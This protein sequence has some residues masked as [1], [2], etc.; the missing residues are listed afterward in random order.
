MGPIPGS[1]DGSSGA[2]AVGS[3]RSRTALAGTGLEYALDSA[4]A[5]METEADLEV[6]AGA[7]GLGSKQGE[8]R[9]G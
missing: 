3:A 7:V 2:G 5:A 4:S 1:T 8:P 9:L 6:A